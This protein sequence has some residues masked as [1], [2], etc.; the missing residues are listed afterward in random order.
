[1]LI[2]LFTD[3]SH[4][5]KT[6]VAAYAAWAKTDGRTVRRAGVLKEPVPDSSVAE[7]Q[8]LVNGLCFALAALKPGADSKIIAQTDC[9]AAIAALTGQLRKPKS[10]ARFAP[11]TAAY[12][13]R[14]ASTGI[15]VEFRH[16]TAHKGVSTPRNAVNTWCDTECRKF[17]RLAR[18]AALSGLVLINRPAAEPLASG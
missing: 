17:M 9:L 10:L 14:V 11:V 16:V 7:A 18:E 13:T 4:C 12:Q 1:M 2:T 3:A 6:D 8:A 5:A 15:M